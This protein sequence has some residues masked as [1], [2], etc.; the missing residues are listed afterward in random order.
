MRCLFD[1]LYRYHP[2]GSM[3]L[4]TPAAVPTAD[5]AEP[6]NNHGGPT[7][8]IVDGQ[9]RITSIYGAVRGDAPHFYQDRKPSLPALRFHAE[10]EA[11]AVFEPS[12][13]GDPLWIDLIDFFKPGNAGLGKALDALY[14]TPTGPT[15]IGEYARRLNQL[16]GILDRSIYVDYLPSDLG[17]VDAKEIFLLA[18]GRG[19]RE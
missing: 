8:H 15:R 4:W 11:F 2:L 13:M 12:M 10:R 6:F 9:Q 5:Q 16:G 7:Q 17:L 14:Q 19:G 18:N 1:S 3:I